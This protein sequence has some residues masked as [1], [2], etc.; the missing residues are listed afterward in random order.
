VSSPEVKGYPID[1]RV[2]AQAPR[3]PLV[4]T[5]SPADHYVSAAQFGLGCYERWL[6]G[7]GEPW[8]DTALRVGQF[9]V[10]TQE[11][12]GSWLNQ[13]PMRHSFLLK[14]PWRCGMAQGEAASLLVRLYR[15]TADE[16]FAEAARSG[17]QPLFRSREQGGV[18]ALL[19][20]SPW[21]EEFPTNPPSFVLNGAI[22]AWWGLRDVGVGLG[23]DAAAKAFADGVDTLA[24]NLE[25]FDTGSW[26]LYCLYPYP[27][28][29]VASSFYHS[30]HITLLEAMHVLAPR[31]EFATVG[32]RWIRYRSLARLRLLA[33]A[34]KVLFRTVIP[35][36]RLLGD[37]LPWLRG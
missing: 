12:D 23:D 22:F 37:R 2:K 28:P 36:N 3:W 29:P 13:A 16:A 17:L 30:L 14:A 31:P 26:S 9:L 21:P 35:R 19:D 11:R 4:P 24:T 7:D 18:C 10:E 25:R 20:G 15:E 34:R 5:R 6:A 33:L 8:L 1:F 32:E 27:V